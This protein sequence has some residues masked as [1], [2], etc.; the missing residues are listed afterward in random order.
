MVVVCS[1]LPG[2]GHF[3]SERF[4]VLP[5]LCVDGLDYW[6]GLASVWDSDE[7]IVNVEHDMEVTDEHVETLLACPHS[8]CSWAYESHWI[9]TGLPRDVISAGTFGPNGR[10]YLDGGEEWAEWSAIGLVKIARD[11]RIG[12]LTEAPWNRLELS[13]ETAVARPWHMHWPPVPHHHW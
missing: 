11:A 3:L 13:V 6:R 7:T 12:P 8:L 5:V 2:E 10:Q 1:H 4:R 9:S